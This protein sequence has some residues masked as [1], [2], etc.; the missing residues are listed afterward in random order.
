M[1]LLM[2]KRLFSRALSAALAG[3]LALS[4]VGTAA[5][6]GQQTADVLWIK[7]DAPTGGTSTLTRTSS[8]ISFMINANELAPNNAYTVW[9]L[10][11]N[12]PEACGKTCK[13]NDVWHKKTG[14]QMFY[15]TGAVSS[16]TGTATFTATFPEG[17]QLLDAE[18]A[19]VMLV[20]RDHGVASTDPAILEEQLTT[21][22]GGCGSP[23]CI[24]KQ[25]VLHTP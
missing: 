5:A 15:A 6:A 19:A 13:Y 16:A 21:M 14:G 22:N 25:Y 23:G 10:V 4:I 12:N 7:Q 8:S 1:S 9:W 24:D 18:T 17:T 20:I 11:Y 3:V 2:T